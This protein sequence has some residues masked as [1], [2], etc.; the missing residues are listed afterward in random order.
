MLWTAAGIAAL[1]ARS[2]T[3]CSSLPM[4]KTT[5][6]NACGKVSCFRGNAIVILKAAMLAALKSDHPHAL[7]E[8]IFL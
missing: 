6:S 5:R 4:M 2:V 1:V 3:H 8:Y 7:D